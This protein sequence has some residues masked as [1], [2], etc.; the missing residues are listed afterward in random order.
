MAHRW[1]TVGARGVPLWFNLNVPMCVAGARAGQGGRG[2]GGPRASSNAGTTH[3]GGGMPDAN[4]PLKACA[5]CAA[6]ARPP[7]A[8][9]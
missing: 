2:A 1:R 6:N 3:G 4:G 7:S 8:R 9:A 5:Y